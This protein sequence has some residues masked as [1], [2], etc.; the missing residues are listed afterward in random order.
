MVKYE[1]F[2]LPNGLVVIVNEDHTTPLAALSLLYKVGSRN[3]N[4]SRTG[5]AH[6][7]EHLMFG[8]SK[9]IPSYD[10]PL[11]RVGG[12]NNAFTS[13]DLTNY[14][15]T[16]PSENL[17]TGFWL[18]SDRMLE[19]DFSQK[20]L[21]VQKNVVSEEFRQRY[22]NQPYGDVWLLLRPEA[23]KVHPY[24][25]PTI[26]KDISHIENASLSDVKDFF[27]RFYAPNNAVLSVSGDVSL[28]EVKRLCDKY[29]SPIEKRNVEG[30]IIP[31]EPGQTSERVMEVKRKVPFDAIYMAYHMPSRLEKGY[32]AFD[33]ISDLLSNG[34]SSRLYYKLVKEKRLFSDINAYITG[35]FDPG[36][37][38]ISGKLMKNVSFKEAEEAIGTEISEIIEGNVSPQE[39]E[40][41][42]NKYE[43][44]FIFSNVNILNKALNLCY[45][46]MLGNVELINS[47]IDRYASISLQDIKETARTFLKPSNC[48]K[49]YYYSEQ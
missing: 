45:F 5:F 2:E 20:S 42:Q 34:R 12:D 48:T 36:L 11:Q 30:A 29:F 14:Y 33:M 24:K 7:F 10:E 41:I 6:L 46:D 32:Y 35:D 37:F 19:L 1:R 31:S 17:E 40:K 22:L 21:D 25:W 26:G 23:Y 4:E 43:S 18:E 15:L 28:Q 39:L 8:G 44:N 13:N 27:Y 9:N 38:V 47:E 3:E 16:L 49:L